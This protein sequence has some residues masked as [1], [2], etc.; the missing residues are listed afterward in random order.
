MHRR[1]FITL[2][3]SAAAVWPLVTQAQQPATPVIGWLGSAEPKGQAPN[4][5]PRHVR[6][7]LRTDITARVCGRTPFRHVATILLVIREVLPCGVLRRA[8]EA[9]ADRHL[10]RPIQKQANWVRVQAVGLAL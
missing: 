5:L 9:S 2:L 7:V 1:E 4:S 8:T 10:E 3:G 6:L